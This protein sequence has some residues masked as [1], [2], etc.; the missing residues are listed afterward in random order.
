[1]CEASADEL[2]GA[3]A[4][5]RAHAAAQGDQARRLEAE[6]PAFNQRLGVARLRQEHMQRPSTLVTEVVRERFG[7]WIARIRIRRARA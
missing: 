2:R 4:T 1:M 3:I 5:A 7:A 6:L